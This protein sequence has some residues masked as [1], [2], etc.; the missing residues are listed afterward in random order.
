MNDK[1]RALV[2]MGFIALFLVALCAPTIQQVFHV[3]P[4]EPVVESR[5]KV[6][7]PP[8]N[9]IEQLWLERGYISD[10]ERHYN[11]VFG[12]R[13]FFIRV[14]NQIQY[15]LFHDSDEVVLGRNGWLADKIT[16][17]VEQR[18]SDH[19]TDADW[20]RLA[21]RVAH[22][23]RIL[24]RRG[25]Y[26][27]VIPVPLKNTVYPEKF[28]EAAALRPATTGYARFV[29]LLA[30]NHVPFVDAYTILSAKRRS[31]DVYYKTDLHWN[32]VGAAAVA[33]EAVDRLG[34][35]MHRDVRWRY[36]DSWKMKPFV[37]GTETNVL[38]ILWPPKY[39]EPVAYQPGDVCGEMTN[40]GTYN[41]LINRCSPPLLPST[42]MFGN[43][44]MMK[45]AAV[46][47]EDYFSTFDRRYDL[48]DFPKMLAEIKPGTK[49]LI[50]Q[51]FELEIGYQLQSD[52]WWRQ[53]DSS[54]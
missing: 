9:P 31:A 54:P 48:T 14:R 44:F 30:E 18:T 4:L 6:P 20:S 12:F 43:S 47:F 52:A 24:R 23:H 2:N 46:G 37:G 49:I 34:S 39:E 32:T 19:L 42:T 5:A 33:A 27:F 50:W 15:S 8:G 45:L 11:D 29:Q 22:L 13:D 17:E 7:L 16:L 40:R 51:L 10:Y 41:E 1:I 38:A 26:L 35:E 21:Q 25:I 36:P 3:V 53:V 28:P